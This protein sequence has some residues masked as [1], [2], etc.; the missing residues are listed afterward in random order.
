MA[1]AIR[2]LYVDDESD[3]LNIGNMFLERSE[4]F[5]VTTALSAPEAIRLLEQEKFDAIISDYQMPGMDGI[6]FLVEVRKHLGQIPFI[7]F[8]G[9]GREEVVIQ[10]INSGADFYLQKGGEPGAQFA[11]L[12]HKVKQAA[13]RKRAEEALRESEEKFRL[14]VENSHDIIYTLTVDGVFSFVSPAW[15]T[16]LGHPVTQ[17]TGQPFQKFVHPDD[18][19]RCMVFLQSVIGTGQRQEGVEYRVQHTNG[20]WYWHTS[21]AVPFK[22]E[23]GM[24]VGFYGIAR[25]ITERKRAEW[26]QLQISDRLLLATR[27]GG[28]GIWDYD[29]VNN[30]LTWDDQMFTLYGITREQ[31]GGAY[32]AWQAGVHPE[33]QVWGDKEVQ[34]ALRGEKEFATE[35][36]VL[37]PDGTIHTLRALA[38]V[39]RDA[40]GKPLRMIGTNWDITRQKEIETQLES[41]KETLEQR[42]RD[43][44]SELSETNLKL[45]KEIKDR[46]KI[47]KKLTISSN[48]KDLLLREVHHRVKNNLQLIIGLVDMTKT[49]AQEPMVRS[50]LTDIMAKVQI[51][52]SIHTRLYES[53]RFDRINMKQQVQDLVDM[54][55]G[56]Y[57]YDH[58]DITTTLDCSEI[59][60]PVD[61]AI[62]CTLALNEIISN[63]HKHAFSGRRNGLVK[64]SSSVKGDQLQFVVRDNGIG[65]PSKFNIEKS[66]RFGL[67][68]M[69]T[70][71]EQQLHGSV[72]I[73]GK[74][75]TEVV[76]EFPINQGDV[77]FG[78]G[79]GS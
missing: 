39:Q 52:G 71:V 18:I 38:L 1:A 44:T 19:P 58:L 25:D 45:I 61:L 47:Q 50:T 24:I 79:T 49:R 17:V 63:I 73:T 48:E 67:K 3:L 16:L 41:Y 28:V 35:F 46:K 54:I 27:A 30:T 15:T 69:R 26:E 64:I 65:L 56:F 53:K 57:D 2:V 72:T 34:Q 12:A 22:D 43:R 33:D 13:L 74:A 68:L 78:T 51:M 77:D 14:L 62:P 36:R 4:E 32:E 10:A 20:T 60:L 29:V 21:S 5:A 70:L 31:F 11:E 23:A 9:R 59:Y 76:M 7:L 6:Q 66:N 55:S 42:V 8:T 37:W 75:G 40:E